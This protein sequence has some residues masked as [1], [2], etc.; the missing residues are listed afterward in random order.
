MLRLL[1]NRS[2]SLLGIDISPSSVK[3]LELSRSGKRYKVETYAIG[4]LPQNAVADKNINDLDVVGEVIKE[5]I[6]K[7]GTSLKRVAVAVSGAAV[8]TKTI[9]MGANL[10]DDDMESQIMIDA[11]QYIPYPL[12]EVAVDFEVQSKVKN[13]NDMVEVLVA[14][15]RQ[16]NVEMRE[17]VLNLAGLTAE[18]VD[19]EIYA[20]ERALNVVIPN[21]NIDVADPVIAVMDLGST[22]T[23]LTVL[24]SGRIIYTRDEMF[25]G[26]QLTDEIMRRYGA[27]I[28]ELES[29]MNGNDVPDDYVSDVLNPFKSSVTQQMTRSL[30]FFYSASY[31]R[32]V[33]YIVLAGGTASTVGLS[34]L[35]EESIEIPCVVGNPFTNMAIARHVNA[36]AL[37]S[38]A[39]AMMVACGLAM[40]SFD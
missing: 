26:R 18:I 15:C 25:G 9:K 17:T 28:D 12:D 5:L 31:H 32:N 1:K 38:D 23:T 4:S 35:I 30:Q 2:N 29:F 3:L 22:V 33:D 34:H 16:E 40:R 21:L 6:E 8:I 19:I 13:N 36:D 39:P 10:S 11:D 7:S 37:A 24:Q 27:G 20:M 14:A